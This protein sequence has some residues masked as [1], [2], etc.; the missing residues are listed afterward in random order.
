MLHRLTL[1]AIIILMIFLLSS[2]QGMFLP[3]PL[4]DAP[5]Y[6]D[7]LEERPYW[8]EL[9]GFDVPPRI[10]ERSISDIMCTINGDLLLVGYDA[11][12]QGHTDSGELAY[13]RHGYISKMTKEGE[14]VWESLI[15]DDLEFYDCEEIDDEIYLVLGRNIENIDKRVVVLY[16]F[17]GDG[18]VIWKKII[19][20]ETD[21]SVFSM[22]QDGDGNV[23]L[24]GVSDTNFG[25][26]GL[27]MKL[28]TEGNLI[29]K[30]TYDDG[31]HEMFTNISITD[32]GDLVLIGTKK[33][34]E[35]LPSKIPH[36][37]HV[38]VVSFDAKGELKWALSQGVGSDYAVPTD[39]VIDSTG[40][41]VITGYVSIN[42]EK[43]DILSIFVDLDGNIMD[44]KSFPGLYEY[45]DYGYDIIQIDKGDLVVF[46]ESY[47]I[48]SNENNPGAL[49]WYVSDT[50]YSIIDGNGEIKVVS[51]VYGANMPS[52][53]YKTTYHSS[54]IAKDGSIFIVISSFNDYEV[55][56]VIP[57]G[58][59][60]IMLRSVAYQ[61]FPSNRGSL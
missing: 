40:T 19:E 57:L 14:L 27:L 16:E 2:V 41:I 56:D 22:T 45:D 4:F 61:E 43:H 54:C 34:L 20:S 24:A 39:F 49:W 33:W 21:D 37:S 58:E 9:I 50:F 42:R 6:R 47:K 30:N 25:Y 32:D 38:L 13:S 60:I 7:R 23:Y 5:S 48:I 52:S 55:F 29:W 46:G 8:R 31:K 36:Y 1:P 53:Q 59:S 3:N 35:F 28:D 17:D 15:D 11:F 18:T 44:C 10:H 26:D 51:K 12:Y